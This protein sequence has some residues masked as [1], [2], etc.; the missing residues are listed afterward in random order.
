MQR[1]SSFAS[2]V[3]LLCLLMLGATSASADSSAGFLGQGLAVA[4]G[5]GAA[6]LMSSSFPEVP[7]GP[8]QTPQPP[9][10][11][12]APEGVRVRIL[13]RAVTPLG[14]AAGR[15][16]DVSGIVEHPGR[17]AGDLRPPEFW[18]VSFWVEL[19][20]AHAVF[21][22]RT[23]SDGLFTF[24]YVIPE[25]GWQGPLEVRDGY[26]S[27]VVASVEVPGGGVQASVGGSVHG[28]GD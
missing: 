22:A 19:N 6:D 2:T 28:A 11:Y 21:R 14:G 17:S 7:L 26:Y 15:A 10:G 3:S 23:R 16:F 25:G 24:R 20:G 1:S 27:Q 12:Q 13:R 18:T 9:P 4:S 8:C 5:L